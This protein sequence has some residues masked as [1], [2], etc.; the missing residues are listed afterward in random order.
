[1][2]SACPWCA[3]IREVRPVNQ[4]GP[5]TPINELSP[6]S[7]LQQEVMQELSGLRRSIR[8]SWVG[9]V[10]NGDIPD[11]ISIES[12]HRADASEVVA[13]QTRTRLVNDTS[14]GQAISWIPSTLRRDLFDATAVTC[15]SHSPRLRHDERDGYRR[16][17]RGLAVHNH[18]R[19]VSFSVSAN[20]AP[21]LSR[22]FRPRQSPS[23]HPQHIRASDTDE[24]AY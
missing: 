16:T 1:M 14:L 22:M 12:R 20:C 18:V 17:E 24:I 15:A 4:T 13:D 9:H 7:I 2:P 8:S 6:H 5:D 11:P 3:H 19:L 10:V 23:A 21:K